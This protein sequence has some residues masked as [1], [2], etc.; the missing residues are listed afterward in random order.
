MSE[1]MKKVSED[2]AS[3]TQVYREKMD[4]VEKGLEDA[5]RKDEIQTIRKE[6]DVRLQ[7]MEEAISA[8]SNPAAMTEQDIEA[9]EKAAVEQWFKNGNKVLSDIG[10][11][12]EVVI[13]AVGDLGAQVSVGVPAEGGHFLPKTFNKTVDGLNRKVSPIRELASLYT[14]KGPGF[15]TPFKT[16]NG[17]AGTRTELENLH[18][19]PVSRFNTVAHT[20]FEVNA[21]QLATYWATQGFTINQPIDELIG[22]IVASLAEEETNQF[23][24]GTYQNVLGN[25]GTVSNGL[26]QQTKMTIGVDRYTNTIGSL[27]GIE[28]ALATKISAQDFLLAFGTLHDR[29]DSASVVMTSRN[30]VIDLMS[31]KD[32]QG[33]YLWSRGDISTGG[34]STLWGKRV[35]TSDY[36]PDF[37]AADDTPVAVFGDFKSI[38]ICDATPIAW[39]IDP[40]TDKRFMKYLGRRLTSSSIVNYNGLRAIYAKAA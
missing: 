4:S 34:M 6:L 26:L 27:A 16:H 23:L 38:A 37:A 2:L 7:A 20:F 21:E 30:T 36:F 25:S 32:G 9:V 29:Y 11:N 28:T 40:Y 17:T 39:T 13:K 14:N 18:S 3:L 12:G 5:V 15:I 35:I 1:D 8:N 31:E 33:N 24:N 19:S 22:D 10:D